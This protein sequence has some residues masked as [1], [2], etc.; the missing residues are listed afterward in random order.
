MF[1]F[2]RNYDRDFVEILNQ[3]Q[4]MNTNSIPNPTLSIIKFAGCTVT[5]AFKMHTE[6]ALVLQEPS[7]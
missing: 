2:N 4:Q 3:K 5:W 6:K 1:K 7:L